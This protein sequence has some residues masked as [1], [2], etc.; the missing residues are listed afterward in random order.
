[1]KHIYFCSAIAFLRLKT[2]IFYFLNI[3]LLALVL[4]LFRVQLSTIGRYEYKKTCTLLVQLFDEAVQNYSTLISTRQ[5]GVD[6]CIQEGTIQF[7]LPS[8]I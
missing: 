2:F 6:C 5:T 1:M 3:F 7:S 8:R 4:S